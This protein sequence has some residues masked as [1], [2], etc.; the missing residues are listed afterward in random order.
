ME[1]F[2]FREETK[3]RQ[4]IKGNKKNYG[5]IFNMEILYILRQ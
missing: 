1:Q 3:N 2:D 5:I 4:S